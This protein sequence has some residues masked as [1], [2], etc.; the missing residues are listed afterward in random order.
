M[1]INSPGINNGLTGTVGA[2]KTYNNEFPVAG[3]DQPSL[4]FRDNYKVLQAGIENLQGR[5]IRIIGE[6]ESDSL[7]PGGVELGSGSGTIS[8]PVNLTQD[9][10]PLTGGTLIGD[11][12]LAG[13]VELRSETG[14][15][16]ILEPPSGKKIVLDGLYWPNTAGTIGQ[17][18]TTNGVA[19]LTWSDIAVMSDTTP[20]LG[21]N[22]NTNGFQILGDPHVDLV[23][24]D[25]TGRIRIWGSSQKSGHIGAGDADLG[26]NAGGGNLRITGGVGDGIGNGGDTLLGVAPGGVS[27]S[28]G[29]LKFEYRNPVPVQYATWPSADGT[30]GQ[31]LVTNGAGVLL[32]SSV[33]GTGTVTNVDT[34]LV[35][36]NGLRTLTDSPIITSGTLKLDIARLPAEVSPPS[37]S[38]LVIENNAGGTLKKT[39]L[40]DALGGT[41][42]GGINGQ[43]QYNNGGVFAGDTGFTTNGAGNVNIVGDLDV[44]NL[45][46]NGNTIS[47]TN[48]NGNI[49]LN[50]NGAG[51]VDINGY[52][53]TE[54]ATTSLT[55][56]ST[57]TLFT[58]TGSSYEGVWI[59][60]VFI[61]L[62]GLGSSMGTVQII[63]NGTLLGLTDARTSIGT[64][65]DT[66][67]AVSSLGTIT[68]SCTLDN[69]LQ[70]GTIV[71]STRRINV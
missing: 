36:T 6:A 13:G 71:Y 37:N 60:Y 12:I 58:Y 33:A 45:N 26:S 48:P 50:S 67:S 70:N 2:G 52:L 66:I 42:V 39:T 19:T 21:G 16:L 54:K 31:V 46:I 5:R 49:T 56:N 22:L 35:G 4:Q 40:A 9:Y 8:I 59:D 1:A 3:V 69:Q 28:K 47:S 25:P 30:S 20:E 64:P 43:I 7:A 41:S 38:W 63:N 27:G 61:R 32:W 24:D 10:L 53:I 62:G 18:L 65:G 11:L 15:D 17:V 14:A 29:T 57:N 44:D 51:F 34:G 55:N 23:S 68:V